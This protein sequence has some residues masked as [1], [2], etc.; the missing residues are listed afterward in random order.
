MPVGYFTSLSRAKTHWLIY[1]FIAKDVLAEYE[2]PWWTA[3]KKVDESAINHLIE[4]ADGRDVN[5]VDADDRTTLLFV[6]GLG[7]ELC[8]IAGHR[9]NSGGLAALHMAAGYVRPGVA[10]LL[11][12]LGADP[13][14]EDDRGRT[15]LDL[16]REILK[17]TLK[18]NPMQFSWR[19]GLES[20]IR[21][22][23]EAYFGER[24]GKR[25]RGEEKQYKK[26]KKIN[27]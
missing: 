21:V 15:T 5:A 25:L 2:T 7:S 14:V 17:V 18:G 22:L 10:K 12:E 6:A 4:V 16:A 20:V 23:D 1:D 24:N 9:D 3:A 27:K 26:K 8:P 11:L 19:I 13:E